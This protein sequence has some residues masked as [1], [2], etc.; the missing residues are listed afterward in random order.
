VEIAGSEMFF[1]TVSRTGTVIDSG[2]ISN[3]ARMRETT[4]GTR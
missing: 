2:V 3:S 4:N 1:E